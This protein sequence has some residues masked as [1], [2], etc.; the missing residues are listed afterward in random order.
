MKKDTK[1]D[2]FAVILHNKLLKITLH[3]HGNS[4]VLKYDTQIGEMVYEIYW[5]FA[6]FVDI[7][8]RHMLL[9]GG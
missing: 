3:R 7:F 2:S 6:F 5:T 9:F 8:F 1:P 4:V